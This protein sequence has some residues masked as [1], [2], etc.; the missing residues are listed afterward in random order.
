[1]EFIFDQIYSTKYGVP[2][3]SFSVTRKINGEGTWAMQCLEGSQVAQAA[4]RG[5]LHS[6]LA[7]W[8]FNAFSPSTLAG[9][10]IQESA[11]MSRDDRSALDQ[12]QGYPL[13]GHVVRYNNAY[14]TESPCKSTRTRSKNA[15]RKASLTS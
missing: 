4:R 5:V 14:P 1:M 13:T 9:K 15:A 8:E 2:M 10:A 12:G 6:A 3:K 7:R 11:V